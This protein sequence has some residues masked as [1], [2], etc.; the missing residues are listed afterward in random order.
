MKSAMESI[1]SVTR[2]VFTPNPETRLLDFSSGKARPKR[3]IGRPML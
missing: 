3:K 2:V 1:I